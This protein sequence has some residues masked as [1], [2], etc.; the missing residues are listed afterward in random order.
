MLPI[1]IWVLLAS[2]HPAIAWSGYPRYPNSRAVVVDTG[3]I[4]QDVIDDATK[5]EMRARSDCAW[6]TIHKPYSYVECLSQSSWN[7]LNYTV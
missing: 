2:F 7:E 3:P 4:T 5:K 1:L 6:A